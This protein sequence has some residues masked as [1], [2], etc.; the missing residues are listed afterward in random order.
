M[1]RRAGAQGEA[2]GGPV[3]EQATARSRSQDASP[4]AVV[5]VSTRRFLCRL[6]WCHP[7]YQTPQLPHQVTSE[8]SLLQGIICFTLMSQTGAHDGLSVSLQP[9]TELKE[10][11]GGVSGHFCFCSEGRSCSH[12][13]P[14]PR[15]LP[16]T[17]SPRSFVTV[18][19]QCFI[20]D[21]WNEK[22]I[23]TGKHYIPHWGKERKE[24]E[25]W[26]KYIR[27]KEVWIQVM[28]FIYSADQMAVSQYRPKE[29]S[30]T[31]EM[32]CTCTAQYRSC[33][34]HVGRGHWKWASEDEELVF[35]GI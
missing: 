25:S 21:N 2:I 4:A 23:T 17:Q 34:P 18:P 32:F 33:Y 24:K 27:S 20:G 8:R 5:S 19:S 1:G 28:I 31:V 12:R 9:V 35:Y 14:L 6:Y 7:G 15:S 3:A 16:N 30:V 13:S 26:L 29:V 10:V 11:G 22:L